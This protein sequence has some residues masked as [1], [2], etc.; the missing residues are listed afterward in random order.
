MKEEVYFD[1]GGVF[2][3]GCC[4]GFDFAGGF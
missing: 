2:G 3:F 4:C 1:S